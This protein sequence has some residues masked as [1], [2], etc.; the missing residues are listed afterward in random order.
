MCIYSQKLRNHLARFVTD[1]LEFSVEFIPNPSLNVCFGKVVVPQQHLNATLIFIHGVSNCGFMNKNV[2]L[3]E[4]RHIWRTLQGALCKREAY[5]F[6]SLMY[7]H[8]NTKG[9]NK[10]TYQS[11]FRQTRSLSSEC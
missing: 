10:Q 3:Q 7:Q 6:L 8:K 9:T 4:I 1:L 5:L 2:S 11:S